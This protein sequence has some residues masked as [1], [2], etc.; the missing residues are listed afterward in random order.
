MV[1]FPL[2][3][4]VFHLVLHFQPLQFENSVSP[5]LFIN[6]PSNQDHIWKLSYVRYFFDDELC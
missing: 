3:T 4:L 5:L 2:L 1:S 6:L